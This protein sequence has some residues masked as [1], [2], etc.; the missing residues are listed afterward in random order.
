MFPGTDQIKNLGTNERQSKN[1]NVDRRPSYKQKCVGIAQQKAAP[2]SIPG[3]PE[4]FSEKKIVD[5]VRLIN[6]AAAW[7]SG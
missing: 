2:S 4:V 7:S 6:S 5:G 3:I 1:E